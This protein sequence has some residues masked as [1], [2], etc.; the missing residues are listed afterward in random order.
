MCRLACSRP[1]WESLRWRG[2][3]SVAPLGGYPYR[4]PPKVF[5]CLTLPSP[6]RC[7]ADVCL[8]HEQL[9]REDSAASNSTLS[10]RSLFE[11]FNRNSRG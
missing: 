3:F 11:A 6:Y 5:S 7:H 2:G 4:F 8:V 1:V 10:L 9:M